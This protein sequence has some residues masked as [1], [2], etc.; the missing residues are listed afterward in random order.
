M[1]SRW[2]L[3]LTLSSVQEGWVRRTYSDRSWARVRA[4]AWLPAAS[5]GVW[6][7]QA[8]RFRKSLWN[9]LFMETD[10]LPAG[11]RV[12]VNGADL[13]VLPAGRSVRIAAQVRSGANTLFVVYPPLSRRI[14][15][16]PVIALKA[17]SRS[18]GKLRPLVTL[19]SWRMREERVTAE[20]PES[21]LKSSESRGWRIIVP[22]P[23]SANDDWL[24]RSAYCAKAVLDV[25]SYWGRRKMSAFFHEIPG[26]PAVYFNGVRLVERLVSPA[27]LDLSGRVKYNGRDTLCLVYSSPPAAGADVA[28]RGIVALRWDPSIPAPRIPPGSTLLYEIAPASFQEGVR[29]AFLYAAQILES[30]AVPFDM[31]WCERG[32]APFPV[33]GP[34]DSLLLPA[35]PSRAGAGAEAGAGR[36]PALFLVAAAWSASPFGQSERQDALNEAARIVG[37]LKEDALKA[38]GM[39]TQT[40]KD[41]ALWIATQPTAGRK[42][43]TVANSLLAD[44]SRNTTRFAKNHGARV[45]PAFDVFRSALRRQRRWP[46]R[47]DFSDQEGVLTPHGSYFLA[48]TLLDTFSL[49]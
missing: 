14:A 29:R 26:E 41:V 39:R 43:G 13:G 40:Q 37:N 4:G 25:P 3:G 1:V 48:L 31:A 44:F 27:R 6:L 49:P 9:D 5:S 18:S 7:R 34:P 11:T 38:A 22:C 2:H 28:G 32:H 21:W 17:V 35:P 20:V 36:P 47:P 15:R 33:L 12:M 46:A 45:I 10:S 30:S 8:F 24:P 23:P 19:K 42:T 16:V